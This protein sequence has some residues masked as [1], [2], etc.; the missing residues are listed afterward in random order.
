[1]ASAV[2]AFI[3]SF[4]KY[5]QPIGLSYEGRQNYGTCCG[6][7]LTLVLYALVISYGFYRIDIDKTRDLPWNLL[8]QT[9]P[10]S[11]VD[12]QEVHPLGD[13]KYSNLTTSILFKRKRAFM[14]NKARVLAARGNQANSPSELALAAQADFENYTSNVRSM[15]KYLKLFGMVERRYA[16]NDSYDV[17]DQR[18]NPNVY[19]WKEYDFSPTLNSD[20]VFQFNLSQ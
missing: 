2:G 17:Y 14:S 16:K 4:D 10:V 15:T 5:A 11:P 18:L 3:R 1:M 8:S 20:N 13:A 6:L 9:V 7:L 12:L 19:S